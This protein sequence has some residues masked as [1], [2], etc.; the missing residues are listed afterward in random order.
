MEA[1]VWASF[2]LSGI[3]ERARPPLIARCH[4]LATPLH[5][6][7]VGPAGALGEAESSAG[8]VKLAGRTARAAACTFHLDK[9]D[10]RRESHRSG[11]TSSRSP[12]IRTEAGGCLVLVTLAGCVFLSL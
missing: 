1:A 5:L 3:T 11:F 12:I 6:A 7:G 2:S 9:S 8:A 10:G 4:P